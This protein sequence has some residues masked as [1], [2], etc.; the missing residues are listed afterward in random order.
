MA[1]LVV[2]ALEVV[3]VEDQQG[4]RASVALAR[5]DCLLRQ[6][7][8]GPAIED[9]GQRIEGGEAGQILVQAFAA[10]Q[11]EARGRDHRHQRRIGE[12]HALHR[13]RRGQ[14]RKVGIR[15]HDRAYDQ[16]R[17]ADQQHRR[18]HVFRPRDRLRLA[19]DRVDA[20]QQHRGDDSRQQADASVQ[21]RPDVGQQDLSDN[22]HADQ[23]NQ[24]D[25]RMA[26]PVERAQGLHE[27][28]E[29][30]DQ[31]R[32]GEDD[33][34]PVGNLPAQREQHERERQQQQSTHP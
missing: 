8:H 16:N 21:G 24:G 18:D 9:A 28:G 5:G 2:D 1:E 27:K 30:D 33:R 20:D 14:H 19:V 6:F 34:N 22:R 26:A 32:I 7:G 29:G 25:A 31:D 12:D 17:N 15:G 23:G 11:Q 13:R 3:D 10:H 4:Q